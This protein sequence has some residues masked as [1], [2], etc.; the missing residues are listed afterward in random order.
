MKIEQQEIATLCI[1]LFQ[2]LGPKDMDS[3]KKLCLT[4]YLL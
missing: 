1:N 2:G 4:L 3:R